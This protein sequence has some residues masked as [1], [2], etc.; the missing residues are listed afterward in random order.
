[1]NQVKDIDDTDNGES[2][3]VDVLDELEM[4]EGGDDA[5]DLDEVDGDHFDIECQ[6]V[7]E[8]RNVSHPSAHGTPMNLRNRRSRGWVPAECLEQKMLYAYTTVCTQGD[9]TLSRK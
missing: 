8:T 2:D 1:M 4:P 7:S 3:V 9:F 5:I 6:G